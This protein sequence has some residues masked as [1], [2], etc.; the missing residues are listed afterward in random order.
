MPKIPKSSFDIHNFFNETQCMTVV[1]AN[2][3]FNIIV[4]K[5]VLLYSVVKYFL[6]INVK[7][8]LM[9]EAI[10]Y[11]QIQNC[12][13]VGFML[14]KVGGKQYKDLKII[15]QELKYLGNWLKICFGLVLF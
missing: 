1:E 10:K 3:F 4:K 7:R 12:W 6:K 13:V 8:K 5:Q 9:Y 2:I 11:G 14:H 15:K